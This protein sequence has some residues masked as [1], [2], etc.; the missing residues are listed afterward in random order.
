MVSHVEVAGRA[1]AAAP[2]RGLL[3]AWHPVLSRKV[4]WGESHLK[5]VDGICGGCAALCGCGESVEG[6]QSYL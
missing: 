6:P 2:S 3:Y 1:S 5:A 4:G